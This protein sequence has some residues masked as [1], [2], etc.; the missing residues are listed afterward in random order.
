MHTF[1]LRL[2]PNQDLKEELGAAASR[3][4]IQAGF[5]L[6]GI[7]S[8]KQATLRFADQ[9]APC[10]LEQKF[11][12]ISL[13]GTLSLNGAHLHI[14]LGDREGKVIGGHLLPGCI[15]YTTAEIVIGVTDEFTFLRRLDQQT[16]FRE[17]EIVSSVTFRG[18]YFGRPI[19]SSD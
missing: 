16:G 10:R 13:V 6:T 5:I 1:A 2:S 3:E 7:G 4:G 12:I 9:V 15:V 18:R 11:E 19:A 8:L 17:L 14:A